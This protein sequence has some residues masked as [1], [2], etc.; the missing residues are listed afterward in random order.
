MRDSKYDILVDLYKMGNT[1]Q[2][3]ADIYGVSK[4]AIY[5]SLKARKVKFRKNSGP[6]NVWY[7]GGK[8][9][10]E[11]RT[12]AN[13]RVARAI[14]SGRLLRKPCEKC[15]VS[16]LNKGGQNKIQAHHNDYRNP[17]SVNWFCRKHHYEWHKNNNVLPLK[18]LENLNE[19]GYEIF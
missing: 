1:L 13:S 2:I 3:L 6:N 10:H 15:G 14:R 4:E 8:G 19:K 5:G 11:L 16:G 7:R 12:M 17:L 18:K 9:R